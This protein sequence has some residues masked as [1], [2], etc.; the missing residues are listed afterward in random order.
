MNMTGLFLQEYGRMWGVTQPGYNLTMAAQPDFV[1]LS[2]HLITA[3]N[4]IGLI[5]NMPANALQ[6]QLNQVLQQLGHL[7]AQ[8]GEMNRLL[9][10]MNG[11]VEGWLGQV[12]AGLQG[13]QN[14]YV[15]FCC[16]GVEHA[17]EPVCSQDFLPMQLVN[18]TV[19][20]NMLLSYPANV[21]R[22][23]QASV[24]SHTRNLLHN[25]IM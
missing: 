15:R 9:E 14:V 3:S 12:E 10:E 4:E 21:Q 8:F 19:S 20:L 16:L 5:P 24:M 23:V 22:P 17:D 13:L 6:L 25:L 11:W 2:Q 18:A 7:R 1:T